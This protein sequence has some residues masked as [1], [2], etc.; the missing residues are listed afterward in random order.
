MCTI[1]ARPRRGRLTS[2]AVH[3]TGTDSGLVVKKKQQDDGAGPGDNIA[4]E[5]AAIEENRRQAEAAMALMAKGASPAQLSAYAG[6]KLVQMEEGF[7]PT[8]QVTPSHMFVDR[9]HEGA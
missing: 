2:K 3:K 8:L 9:D 1:S 5:R 6:I 7:Q 4:A